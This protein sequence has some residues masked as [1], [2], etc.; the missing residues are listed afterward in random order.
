M[1]ICMLLLI[2]CTWNMIFRAI[3]LL[4]VNLQTKCGKMPVKLASELTLPQMYTNK[5][6]F[7]S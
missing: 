7:E 5:Q 4:S 2:F 6:T 1:V 3:L